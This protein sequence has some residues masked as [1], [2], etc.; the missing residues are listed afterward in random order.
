M[1]SSNVI[2]PRRSD[3]L[4]RGWNGL[5][6]WARPCSERKE[7][8]S[9]LNT[10][11]KSLTDGVLGSLSLTEQ[12]VIDSLTEEQQVELCLMDRRRQTASKTQSGKLGPQ[13]RKL[14]EQYREANK[15]EPEPAV[16]PPPPP[17]E[18]SDQRRDRIHKAKL[19]N[20]SI[21]TLV[22]LEAEGEIYRITEVFRDTN[23]KRYTDPRHGRI[24]Q[25]L[26]FR[27]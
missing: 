5:A 24:D 4:T 14:F 23:A 19:R 10:H 16:P 21:N 20:K 7:V 25:R 11:I 13:M 17:A 2:S 8:L 6:A 12:Q 1:R 18:T 27:I 15:P 26:L 3:R 22:L 9:N